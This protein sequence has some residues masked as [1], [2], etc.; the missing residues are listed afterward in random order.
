MELDN[1]QCMICLEAINETE[2]EN[3]SYQLT[4]EHIFHTKCIMNW[5]RSR[6]SSGNCPLCNDKPTSDPIFYGSKTYYEERFKQI[7]KY[8]TKNK[9]DYPE[10]KNEIHK[11]KQIEKET[12]KL[13]KLKNDYLK[14]NKEIR[15]IILKNQKAHW[16]SSRKEDKE[17]MK[18]IARY[19]LLI[20]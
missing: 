10:L 19:P 4:C 6:S 12:I 5:F 9:A 14:E 16:S 8:V 7:K 11:I 15:D 1:Y 2:T 20:L 13:N 3:N 17:K 18:L